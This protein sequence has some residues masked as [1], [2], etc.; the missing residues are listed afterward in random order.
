M[1]RRTVCAVVYGCNNSTSGGG[2]FHRDW[3]VFVRR[4]CG[5]S[6]NYYLKLNVIGQRCEEE[7]AIKI[8]CKYCVVCSLSGGVD[9]AN[10]LQVPRHMLT[11][12]WEI[13]RMYSSM[14]DVS[15]GR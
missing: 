12:R 5:C 2:T 4:Q 13:P 8:I 10:W 3:C 15:R 14:N 7:L 9:Y 6:C 11:L 1:Y